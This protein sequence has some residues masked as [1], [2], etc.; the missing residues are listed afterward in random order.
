MMSNLSQPQQVE[1]INWAGKIR[2]EAHLRYEGQGENVCSG[3]INSEKSIINK[4]RFKQ[5]VEHASLQ[6]R[7]WRTPFGLNVE[8]HSIT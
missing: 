5:V 2:E 3:P 8:G 4:Q 1:T 6:L 7:K